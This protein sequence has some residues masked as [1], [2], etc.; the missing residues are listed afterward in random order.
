MTKGY[1]QVSNFSIR[2]AR[3]VARVAT[4]SSYAILGYAAAQAPGPRVEMAASTLAAVRKVVPLPADDEL[5]VRANGAVQAVAGAVLVT[6]VAQ[7]L[8]AAVLAASLIPTTIAGHG[9][10]N[11]DDPMAR[12]LQ[13]VQ[14]QKNLAMLGG[15]LFAISDSDR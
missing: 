9:F 8:S 5:V 1:T 11:I 2:A 14:F 6:G 7:R 10:W 4:G 15:L 13:H 12:K 3:L